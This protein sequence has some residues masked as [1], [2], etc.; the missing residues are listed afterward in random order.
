MR[1]NPL[2]TNMV[3]WILA[4][5]KI[6]SSDDNVVHLFISASYITNYLVVS[7]NLVAKVTRIIGNNTE[8]SAVIDSNFIFLNFILPFITAYMRFKKSQYVLASILQR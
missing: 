7:Y 2:S 8:K 6:L 3:T 1:I 4:Q 5:M